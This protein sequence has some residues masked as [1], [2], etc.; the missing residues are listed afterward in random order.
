SLT[1][2]SLV[3]MTVFGRRAERSMYQQAEGQ[4]GA[5]GAA[6]TMLRG[7][8]DVKQA[9]GFTKQQDVV[10]RVIGR[11]GVVLVGE[12]N[13]GRTRTL[14]ANE[15]KKHQRIVGDET[16]VTTLM[17]GRGDGQVPLPALVKTVRKLPKKIK[18]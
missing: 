17:V 3:T 7:R 14:L 15:A 5:G 9:V 16:P 8:W 12:G 2:A 13:P 1:S 11:P 6:L 4:L 18:P 10:H